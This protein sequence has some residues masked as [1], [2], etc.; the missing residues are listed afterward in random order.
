MAGGMEPGDAPRFFEK[1][2]AERLQDAAK[3]RIITM[4]YCFNL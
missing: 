4:N 1:D 3:G 2:C